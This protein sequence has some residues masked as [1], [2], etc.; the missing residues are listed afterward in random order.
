MTFYRNA[1]VNLNVLTIIIILS[2]IALLFSFRPFSEFFPHLECIHESE[3]EILT[4]SVRVMFV[5]FCKRDSNLYCI[6]IRENKVLCRL[7]SM[8][9]LST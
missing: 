3:L 5:L 8:C 9:C 2:K 6:R 1:M 4:Q 7:K